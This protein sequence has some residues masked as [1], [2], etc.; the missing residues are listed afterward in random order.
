MSV[1][2]LFAAREAAWEKYRD[3]LAD[4]LE[5]A[6]VQA[7]VALEM[8]PEDVDYIVY[9][10][11]STVQ[12]FAPYT[13]ARAV[14]NL[15]AGVE[16]V[17]DNP[18]LKIPLARMVDH[19]LTQGMRDWV[20]AHV[21]RHHVGLDWQI[22]LQDGGWRNEVVPPLAQDRPVGVLGLGE[23]GADCAGA[24]VPAATDVEGSHVLS[25]GRR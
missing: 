16:D 24:L 10:P 4:A 2:V 23:L 20:C 6:G 13:R 5:I 7:R 22:A 11:N 15:W 19:G 25:A 1:N 14:L 17:V 8:A 18:T 21:L 9:A 12:D 3:P